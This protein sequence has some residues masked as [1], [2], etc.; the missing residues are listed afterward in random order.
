MKPFIYKFGLQQQYDNLKLKNGQTMY[1]ITDT[2][3][4]YIGDQLYTAGGSSVIDP[5][6]IDLS[7][8]A[9]KN[10]VTTAIDAIQF[11]EPDL[12]GY[13]TEQY[14]N[15][16]I[17]AIPSVDFTGYAT[18]QYVDNASFL[19]QLSPINNNN[20][21][22]IVIF[23]NGG[24]AV[25]ASNKTVS[26]ITTEVAQ[27][28]SDI[29]TINTVSLP[30]KISKKSP[31][32][33]GMLVKFTSEGDIESSS[34]AA[35]DVSSAIAAANNITILTQTAY[36]A[37]NPKIVNRIYVTSDTNKI[38]IGDKE[39]TSDTN[40]AGD[41]IPIITATPIN[42]NENKIPL[43]TDV[44]TLKPSTYTLQGL[45]DYFISARGFLTK[46]DLTVLT[47]AE[48]DELQ[49]INPNTIYMTTD[50]QKIY[51]GVRQHT[52]GTSE[53][54]R[55]LFSQ[56]S[57]ATSVLNIPGNANESSSSVI[58][59]GIEKE[60][61]AYSP[62]VFNTND[63]SLVDFVIYGNGESFNLIHY[64]LINAGDITWVQG[65]I[66]S[67]GVDQNRTDRIRSSFIT[68]PATG[69]YIFNCNISNN[70][71]LKVIAFVYDS[72][73]A[74]LY[75][76]PASDWMDC[77]GIFNLS[78]LQ[79][80]NKLKI[81]FAY[82]DYTTTIYPSII[83]N[84]SLFK[85]GNSTNTSNLIINISNGTLSRNIELNIQSLANGEILQLSD[86][87]ID[88]PTYT[89]NNILT[90]G[91]NPPPMVYIRYKE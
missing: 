55:V 44:G 59:A 73:D 61:T 35:A 77:T 6:N 48:Y 71:N 56:N 62:L 11:P 81:I 46:D 70:I 69:D 42:A 4:I 75:K 87:N 82:S 66:N 58:S 17:D 41:Y 51:M 20:N 23:S 90:V 36:N 3:K 88:I 45:I 26:E 18:Q 25:S 14:V 52:S 79:N 12:T 15:D 49:E 13:A 74:F 85:I 43:I 84:A 63:T 30:N 57:T 65:S 10:Y 5:S 53:L 28:A 89:G 32:P 21:D 31:A 22:K 38:Y 8:Y 24:A 40:A 16:A 7:N 33:T 80:G 76:I 29:S 86:F 50:T 78:N 91:I 1:I 19:P 9:T 64:E 47:Q 72:N 60:I 83:S 34:I 67:S 68:I 37:L 54:S 27:N 39:Y 2:H